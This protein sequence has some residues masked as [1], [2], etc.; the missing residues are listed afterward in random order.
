MDHLDALVNAALQDGV[1]T[2]AQVVVATPQ[3]RVHTGAY[4][5]AWPGGPPVTPE[6]A[7]DL[8]SL[9]KVFTTFICMVLKDRGALDLDR[10]VGDAL[11]DVAWPEV[12][13]RE[14]LGHRAGLVAWQPWFDAARRH[15]ACAGLWPDLPGGTDRGVAAAVTWSACAATP[16]T[17]AP[18][19]VYS[20][21]GFIALGRLLE[22]ITST[23]LD[24]LLQD[25]V[26]APLG[27][28]AAYRRLGA[29][30]LATPVT[31]LTRPRDPAP[32]QAELYAV[33]PQRPDFLT[34][35]VDDDN[36]WA[37]GG[38]AGHAGVFGTAPDVASLGLSLL[39]DLA[40]AQTLVHRDTAAAFVAPDVP[41]L[42][43]LRSLGLD[44][45]TPGG[46][47]GTVIGRG[48]L[49]AVGHLGFVGTSLWIDLD[50]E[51]VVVLLTN[52]VFPSRVATARIRTLRPAV[53]DAAAALLPRGDP[54]PDPD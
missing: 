29:A 4:G 40:G 7:F 38:V 12:T 8:A 10:R 26:C 36:A 22:A 24:V 16:G 32:G 21:L 5:H 11:P 47:T 17:G 51:A 20:D 28:S 34:G 54:A 41:T 19:R 39:R 25:L 9:T 27:L 3:H 31:G 2:A 23:R 15:K 18:A 33:H 45:A 42:A 30:P 13:V 53:H 1:G 49:G 43:P 44:R 6:T 50:R 52:R 35:E 37:L 14:L 46:S 48:P